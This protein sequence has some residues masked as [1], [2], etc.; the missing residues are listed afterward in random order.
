MFNKNLATA[1]NL[2]KTCMY[3]H[4]RSLFHIPKHQT[5]ECIYFCGNS[6][7]VQ[8]KSVRSFIEQELHDW[9]TLGVEGHFQGKN[10]WFGYHHFLT[11]SAARLVGALP[12]EVVVMNSLTVNLHLMMVS[13]YRP[14]KERYKIIIEGGAFPSDLYAV[15]TQ[16]AFHGFDPAD[17]IIELKP[18]EGEFCLQNEDILAAINLH[19]NSVALVML[20]GVNYYTGQ[21]YDLASITQKA[22]E[23]GAVAGFD[24]A[25]AAGNVPLKLHDWNVDFAV[26]CSY[27][28]LNSGPGGTSGTF[29]HERHAS[30]PT[31][32]R[33]GGWWGNSEE[34]RFTM[35]NQFVPQYGAAGWQLSNA[36]ILPMAAHRASLQ[37]FD[38]FGMDY[39]REKSEKM[40]AYL[41]E[42]LDDINPNQKHFTIITPR[43]PQQ[44]GCQ[45]SILMAQN[46]RAVFDELTKQG[47]IADW[48]HPNVIRVAPVPLYNTFEEIY[49]F[50]ETLEKML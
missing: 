46:G 41:F 2:D 30:S 44:R 20:G 49:R 8:P 50:V 5:E 28:Y 14:T 37:I 25:H 19:A 43:N 1:Y 24:L 32:P 10:P 15:Q 18:R 23:V 42:L 4:S 13:F 22:H 21:F 33:F 6:L 35:P 39:L 31:L 12:H 27:K 40:S 9:E 16:A 26:W 7:G 38:E 45:V 17:A 34:T 11:E 47:I 36:Q 48:R 29:V 3:N